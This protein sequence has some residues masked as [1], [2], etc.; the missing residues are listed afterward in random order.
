[1]PATKVLRLI[2]RLW[3]HLTVLT[4][5]IGWV[6]TCAILVATLMA[7]ESQ[8]RNRSRNRNPSQYKNPNRS[9]YLNQNQNLNRNRDRNRGLN[10]A[11]NQ[12]TRKSSLNVTVAVTVANAVAIARN[13]NKPCNSKVI[14]RPNTMF[15]RNCTANKRS[16]MGV[17][18]NPKQTAALR[19]RSEYSF[20]RCISIHRLARSIL[21]RQAT[22]LISFVTDKQI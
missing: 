13:N 1:M 12:D 5:S 22:A 2:S 19:A 6:A 3:R 21:R 18:C 7:N 11:Q 9:Q 14:R 17:L 16:E 15:Y 4:M 10:R 20:L 8:V